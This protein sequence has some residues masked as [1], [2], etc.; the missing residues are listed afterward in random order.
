L[1]LCSLGNLEIQSALKPIQC[2][3]VVFN[4]LAEII[5]YAGSKD[6]HLTFFQHHLCKYQWVKSTGN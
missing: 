4:S 5:D 3:D 6:K 2:K 1:S